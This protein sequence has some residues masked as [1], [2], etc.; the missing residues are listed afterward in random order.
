[1]PKILRVEDKEGYGCY[2]NDGMYLN[3][4][5]HHND[6]VYSPSGHPHPLKDLGIERRTKLGERHGFL[7]IEQAKE[8]FTLEEFERLSK[9]GYELK[10]LEVK[11][12]TAIGNK[13][14]LFIP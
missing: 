13:Q 12:I 11:K 10:E 2:C 4:L 1:M 14:I 6:D 7:D 8:W 9:N 3:N 5:E